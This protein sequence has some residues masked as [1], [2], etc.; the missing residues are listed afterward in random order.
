MEDIIRISSVCDAHLRWDDGGQ[1]VR[2]VAVTC[3]FEGNHV[4]SAAVGH[5]T[6]SNL[7]YWLTQWGLIKS[8]L[9]YK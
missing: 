5:Y 2:I 8:I 9:Q 3:E 7:R 4:T 6:S 1:W